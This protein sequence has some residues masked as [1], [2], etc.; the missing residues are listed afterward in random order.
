MRKKVMLLAAATV[1]V[2]AAIVWRF[3]G[4]ND[5]SAGAGRRG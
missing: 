2:L 3:A 1:V 5:E 4:L